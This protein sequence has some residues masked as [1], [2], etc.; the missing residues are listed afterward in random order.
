MNSRRFIF[1]FLFAA[2]VSACHHPKASEGNAKTVS[3]DEKITISIFPSWG[4][5]AEAILEH[6]NGKDNLYSTYH[7]K[8]NGVDTTLT[9]VTRIDPST[10]DSVFALAEKVKWNDD[11]HRGTGDARTGLKFDMTWKKGRTEKSVSWENLKNAT[12][13]PA[14][15]FSVLQILNRLSPGDF[16]LY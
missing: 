15:I 1:T 7:E 8:I 3:P 5:S 11:A 12:E 2:G 10:A 13:L 4:G 6:K 16:K 14:D 9:Q